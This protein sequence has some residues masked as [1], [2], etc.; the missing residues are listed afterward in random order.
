VLV[1][2]AATA[3]RDAVPDDGTDHKRNGKPAEEA[4]GEEMR[5]VHSAD[6]RSESKHRH[7]P[8]GVI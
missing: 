4:D 7:R 8:E 1:G 6:H 2:V 3:E 5:P